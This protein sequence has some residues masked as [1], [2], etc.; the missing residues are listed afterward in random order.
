MHS[1]PLDGRHNYHALARNNFSRYLYQDSPERY[2][3][4]RE[5]LASHYQQLLESIQA[6]TGAGI[7]KT[8]E[9]LELVLALTHQLFLLPDEGSHINAIEKI[10]EAYKHTIIKQDGEIIR[11]LRGISEDGP[12]NTATKDAQRIA[13]SLIQYIETGP[14]KRVQEFLAATS[15]FIQKLSQIVPSKSLLLANIYCDRGNAYDSLTRDEQALADFDRAIECNSSC[16]RAYTLRAEVY[17]KL[18]NYNDALV[19]LDH[20]IQLDPNDEGLFLMRGQIYQNLK[21]DEDALHD[22]DYAIKLDMGSEPLSYMLKGQLLFNMRRYKQANDSLTKGLM[23]D[24]ELSPCWE[25]LAQVYRKIHPYQEIPELL[26]A[27]SIPKADSKRVIIYRARA[28][29]AIGHY[30]EALADLI[31]IIELEPQNIRAIIE[32]GITY[33]KLERHEEAIRNFTFALELDSNNIRALIYRGVTYHYLNRYL[34]A[35]H[36]Y[37]RA[38]GHEPNDANLFI[39]RSSTYRHMRQ[40]KDALK[41]LDSA[42]KLNPRLAHTILEKRGEVLQAMGNNYEALNIFIEALNTRQNCL[43]CWLNL[44]KEYGNLHSWGEVPRL[45]REVKVVDEKDASVIA[46]RGASMFYMNCYEEALIELNIALETDPD[47]EVALSSRSRVYKYSD[48]YQ[49]ALQDLESAIKLDRYGKHELKEERGENLQELGKNEEAYD[50]FIEALRLNPTC[51]ACWINLIVIHELLEGPDG[52]AQWLRELS[53]LG[54]SGVPTLSICADALRHLHYYEEALQVTIE[55]LDLWPNDFTIMMTQSRIYSELKHYDKA[56]T[57]LSAVLR[58]RPDNAEAILSRGWIY[59]HINK[60]RE[61]LKDFQL[62]MKLD[63]GLEHEGQEGKGAVFYSL[64]RYQDA[65][66]AFS[67]ALKVESTCTECWEK[68]ALTYE[69]F[70]EKSKVPEMLRSVKITD[71]NKALAIA[72]R[73]GAI[74]DLGYYQEALQDINYAFA[75]DETAVNTHYTT[76]GLIFSYLKHYA[77]AIECYKR[78][79]MYHFNYRNLYNIAVVMVRWNNLPNAQ[80]FI[81]AAYEALLTQTHT[82]NRV[83]AIYGLG[84]L[85]AVSGNINQALIYLQQAISFSNSNKRIIKWAKHDI[86]WLELRSDK[87]FQVLI[88]NQEQEIEEEVAFFQKERWEQ[89]NNVNEDEFLDSKLSNEPAIPKPQPLKVFLCYSPDDKTAVQNLYHRLQADGIDPWLD[90]K[91]LLPGQNRDIEIQKAVHS[92]DAVIVCLS[93]SVQSTTGQIHKHILYALNIADEQPEDE[94]FLI[95]AKLEECNVPG[96]LSQWQPVNLQNEEGY[97]R[98]IK[99]LQLKFPKLNRSN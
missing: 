77:E 58:H 44:A 20:A 81:D 78:V 92:S 22:F 29:N 65:A 88:S 21:R 90:E 2:R 19:D 87:R 96:R 93:S 38:I 30:E 41:D 55:A 54:F 25:L 84:G 33:G 18:N 82:I 72:Q 83:D 56:Q 61:A 86:A 46:C 26:K 49:K 45:L 62:A 37:N 35:L 63:L 10:L 5:T 7:Y 14:E 50:T 15:F 13:V 79:P 80:N 16:V 64:Q 3:S 91:N 53:V 6:E 51:K 40:F 4:T 28:L 27:L 42:I 36:D 75:L 43:E 74:S 48:I 71:C 68:L 34:D 69:A 76:R 73:A 95:P 89:Q 12:T 94:I 98:L 24:P 66:S 60:P 52:T 59:Y 57:I 99:S 9:W 23:E 8:A 32:L 31:R 17:R 97:E 85:E 39:Y 11:F 67:S 70:C 47:N 1:N